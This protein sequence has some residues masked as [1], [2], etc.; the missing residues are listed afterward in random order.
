VRVR[1]EPWADADPEDL[2]GVATEACGL[3]HLLQKMW[4]FGA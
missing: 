3:V 2:E 1:G 4:G